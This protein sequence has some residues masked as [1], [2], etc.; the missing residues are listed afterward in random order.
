MKLTWK[1]TLAEYLV[2][3]GF[4]TSKLTTT[5][6]LAILL[7]EKLNVMELARSPHLSTLKIS[8]ASLDDHPTSTTTQATPAAKAA[9]ATQ[10][11]P[12][13]FAF[14][15]RGCTSGKM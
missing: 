5:L 4:L 6:L 10:A 3:S 14:L 7:E 9:R 2:R 12:Q 13:S 8:E 15:A 1:W 11:E